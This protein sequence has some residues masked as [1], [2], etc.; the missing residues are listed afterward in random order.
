M[1]AKV[2]GV[3]ETDKHTA[4]SLVPTDYIYL[5]P[6]PSAVVGGGEMRFGK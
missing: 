1:S 3:R 4:E 5:V 6:K 2:H